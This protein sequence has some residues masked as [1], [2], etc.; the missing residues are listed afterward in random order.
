[1]RIR[2]LALANA[3]AFVLTLAMN[4]LSQ[5]PGVF[6]YTSAELGEARAIFFLPAGYVFGIWGIIYFGLGAYITYQLRPANYD[7]PIH[8]QIGVLFI[9]S[10]IGNAVW[11]VLFL[12]EQTWLSTLAMLLLLGSLIGIYVRLRSENR[13]VTPLERWAVWVP[14]SIYLGWITVATVANFAAALF[15]SGYVTE[16]VGI[17]ADVWTVIMIGVAAVITG[18]MLFTRRDVAYALVV[19]WALVGIYARPFDTPTYA[20]VAA[21]NSGLVD[22]AALVV[23][24]VIAVLTAISLFTGRVRARTVQPA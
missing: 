8:R 2:P 6:P 17:T 21:L 7:S 1:M 3:L 10:C 16:F 5:A 12:N 22:T 11:L 23:A 15:T 14:F 13:T 18:L 20:P 9:L 24:I 19:V 4:A